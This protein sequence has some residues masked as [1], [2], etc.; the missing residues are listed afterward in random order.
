M[1]VGLCDLEFLHIWPVSHYTGFEPPKY[2]EWQRDNPEQ[3][4]IICFTERCYEQAKEP[5]FK[6]CIRCAWPLEPASIHKYAYEDILTKYKNIF[7]YVFCFDNNYIK[8]FMDIGLKPII[9]SPGGSYIYAKDWKIYPKSKNIQIIAS[10]KDWTVGHRLRHEVIKKYSK[11]IDTVYGRAYQYYDYQLEP[12]KDH[13]FAIVI[14]NEIIHN[15]WTDKLL[16]CFLTG[17]VP[18]I[19]NDGFIEDYFNKD[20]MILWKNINELNEILD[21]LNDKL[22]NNM[23]LAIQ[24]NFQIAKEKYGIIENFMYHQFFYEFDK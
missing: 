14:E 9:W 22:Y 18:V 8:K 10:H 13:R 7:D 4:K 23:M 1:K 20:G 16:D 3:C 19:W 15:Y 11:N 6:D 5:R 24:D 21:T 2:I 17:T 12:F